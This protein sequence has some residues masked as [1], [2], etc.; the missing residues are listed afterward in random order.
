M[1]RAIREKEAG[2]WK[3]DAMGTRTRKAKGQDRVRVTRM[4]RV[5]KG[6]RVSPPGGRAR[7]P[8]RTRRGGKKESK[9]R[10][11]VSEFRCDGRLFP[12]R[13][14]KKEKMQSHACHLPGRHTREDREQGRPR[15][16]VKEMWHFFFSLGS[17]RASRMARPGPWKRPQVARA[18]FESPT[19]FDK[20]RARDPPTPANLARMMTEQRR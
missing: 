12:G 19:L 16:G 1:G 13:S 18:F 11:G 7:V 9:K 17:S 14:R 5:T 10:S 2:W 4:Q 3:P 8:R 20:P 6:K 15:E